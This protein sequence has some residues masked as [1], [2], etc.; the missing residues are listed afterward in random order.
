MRVSAIAEA[1]RCKERAEVNTIVFGQ[2]R[3]QGFGDSRLSRAF[4][5]SE[6]VNRDGPSLILQPS[7]QVFHDLDPS[8]LETSRRRVTRVITSCIDGVERL[9]KIYC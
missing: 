7:M 6:P 8:V 5:S 1:L 3:A 4:K 9:Q 2:F